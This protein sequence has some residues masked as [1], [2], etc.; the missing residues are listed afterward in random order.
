MTRTAVSFPAPVRPDRHWPGSAVRMQLPDLPDAVVPAI[1]G[2]HNMVITGV[3]GTG[4]VIVGAVLA[5][6]AHVDGT[7]VDRR[8]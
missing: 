4:V 7:G 8:I 3:G 6:A 5:M 2:T 1:N